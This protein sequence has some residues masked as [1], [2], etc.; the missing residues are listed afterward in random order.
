MVYNYLGVCVTVNVCVSS[1]E[2]ASALLVSVLESLS[3]S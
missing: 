1:T 2:S 3:T